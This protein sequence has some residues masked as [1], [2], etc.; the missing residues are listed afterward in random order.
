[1]D[2]KDQPNQ[3]PETSTKSEE[4]A[5]GDSGVAA[6]RRKAHQRVG[7]YVPSDAIVNSLDRAYIDAYGED[8]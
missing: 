5:P 8:W 7:R 6:W 1:M 4:E 3:L 2:R